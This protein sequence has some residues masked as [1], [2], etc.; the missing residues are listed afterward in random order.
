[1]R[2]TILYRKLQI[3]IVQTAFENLGSTVKTPPP[4]VKHLFIYISYEN[5]MLSAMACP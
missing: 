2:K 4:E 1:M 5:I 3:N